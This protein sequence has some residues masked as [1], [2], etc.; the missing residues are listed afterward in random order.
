MRHHALDERHALAKTLRSAGPGAPTLCGEWSSAHLAAHLVLRER[1]LVELAG[2]LPVERLH[3]ASE[4]LIARVATEQP[5]DRLVDLFE[6]GPSWRDV[7]WPLPTAPAWTLPPV[8]ELANLTEY[9]I[10]HE[11]VRRAGAG[12]S[13]RVLP[14]DLQMAVWKRAPFTARI[15]M[16][17]VSVPVELFWPSHGVVRAGRKGPARVQIIGDPVELVLFASGR[18]EHAQVEFAGEPEDVALVCGA[19]IGL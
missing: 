2:R 3:A 15:A 9:L 10:H 5:Y 16:R 6:E 13:P 1:S 7:R 19:K 11:D 17:K 4:R 14:V 12:W 8:R 18:L